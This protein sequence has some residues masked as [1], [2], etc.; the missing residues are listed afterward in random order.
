ME[1]QKNQASLNSFESKENKEFIGNLE[2][3]K[4]HHGNC[5]KFMSEMP[6]ESVDLVVTDPPFAIKFKAKRG[7]YNRKGSNVLEGYNEIKELDY[8]KFSKDWIKEAFRVLKPNGAMYV[9]SGWNNL[10][11]ILDALDEVGFTTLNHLIWKYQFGVYCSKKFVTSHYHILYVVKNPKVWTFNKQDQYPEDVLVI[12]REY[13]TGKIKTPTKLPTAL[14]KKLILCSS[15]ENDIIMDCFMGSG[16]TAVV[17]KMLKRRFVGFDMVEDYV[18]F[19]NE[20]LK[21][22]PNHEINIKETL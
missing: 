22:T 14:L 16:Q 4:I 7:N 6:K 20:R 3:N 11:D 17:S 8:P 5:I 21:K 18:N 10:K 15:N 9:F 19:A 12:N 2:L 13:W 1:N